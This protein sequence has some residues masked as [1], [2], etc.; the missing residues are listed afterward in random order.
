MTT[1]ASCARPRST[2]SS[3]VRCATSRTSTPGYV[4]PS[5]GPPAFLDQ[6]LF[7]LNM[8]DGDELSIFPDQ[9]EFLHRLTTSGGTA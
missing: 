1:S 6:D 4:V 9:T 3:P 7:G 2:P 8:I 5:A